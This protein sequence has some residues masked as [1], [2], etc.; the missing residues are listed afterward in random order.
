MYKLK[1]CIWREL[2]RSAR[3]VAIARESTGDWLQIKAPHGRDVEAKVLCAPL[4]I[5][6]QELAESEANPSLAGD[7]E[8]TFLDLSHETE[9]DQWVN[10]F[11]WLPLKQREGAL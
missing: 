10:S 4:R 5:G 6:T 1:R 3:G 2:W 8:G 9:T 11:L 7:C